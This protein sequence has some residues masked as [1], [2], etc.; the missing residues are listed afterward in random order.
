MPSA[1]SVAA[2]ALCLGLARGFVSPGAKTRP[3]IR[4]CRMDHGDELSQA[5]STSLSRSSLLRGAGQA[6][7]V[8]AAGGVGERKQGE[9][10][11]YGVVSGVE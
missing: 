8:V 1:A 11:G 10:S 9:G 6:A 3:S 7:A 4:P 2:F 5:P